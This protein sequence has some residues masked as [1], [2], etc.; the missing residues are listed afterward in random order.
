MKKS[1]T[2]NQTATIDGDRIALASTALAILQLPSPMQQ[3][4]NAR[5]MLDM[6]AGEL[7][8][9]GGYIL[10]QAHH[11]L[12]A[13]SGF[14]PDGHSEFDWNG[15]VQWRADVEK[16]VEKALAKRRELIA[17]EEAF[18]AS[19]EGKALVASLRERGERKAGKTA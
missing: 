2:K 12:N 17:E 18:S 14:V 1:K 4:S 8:T 16:L 13:Y 19:D 3:Y 6:L 10:S 7:C 15:C 11:L 5:D 9:R